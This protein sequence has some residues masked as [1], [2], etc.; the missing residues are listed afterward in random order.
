MLTRIVLATLAALTLA[1]CD[2]ARGFLQGPNF[3]ID[4]RVEVWNQTL[5]PVFLVDSD[6]RRLDVPACGHVVAEQLNM[7]EV[8]VRTEAGYIMGFGGA[9]GPTHYIVMVA[10]TAAISREDFPPTGIPPC[11]GHM[12]VQVGI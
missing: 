8:R 11:Q 7:R 6:G 5:D 2:A 9:E 4:V 10:D 1:G 12:F 3:P